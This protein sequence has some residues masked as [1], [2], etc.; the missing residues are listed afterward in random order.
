MSKLDELRADMTACQARGIPIGHMAPQTVLAL[1][2]VI[3]AAKEMRSWYRKQ[4]GPDGPE[5]GFD[6]ALAK[7]EGEGPVDG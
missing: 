5:D 1:L 4:M 6:A 3:E 7:L 2:D